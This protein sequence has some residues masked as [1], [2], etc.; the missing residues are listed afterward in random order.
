MAAVGMVARPSVPRISPEGTP[1]RSI[2]EHHTKCVSVGSGKGYYARREVFRAARREGVKVVSRLR[3]DPAVCGLPGPGP[4]G[5]RGRPSVYGRRLSLAMRAGQ[6][7]GWRSDEFE[8]YGRHERWRY[9]TFLA[10][11]RL[12]GRVMRV[13]LTEQAKGAGRRSS[14]PI[15]R[16][17]WL[18]APPLD[19]RSTTSKSRAVR[20]S[21][22][23]ATCGQ[24]SGPST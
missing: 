8:L 15:P 7:R 24:T 13:V 6:R 14:V 22:S 4:P 11:W 17:R 19:G 10:T 12:A 1:N 3:R 21:S 20:A 2:G 18:P 23:C 16:R 5:R 9:R